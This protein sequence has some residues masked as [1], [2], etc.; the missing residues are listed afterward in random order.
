MKPSLSLLLIGLI[1]LLSGCSLSP[2]STTDVPDSRPADLSVHYHWQ[3]GSLP[4]PFH[5]EYNITLKPQGQG[6]VV[7]TPDYPSDNVPT[8]TETFTVSAAELD[9]FYQVLFNQGLF[10]Q[11]WRAQ[12]VP[13]IGG[14]SQSVTVM[15]H[16][17]K[18]EIPAYVLPE[19][20]AAA[21]AICSAVRALVPEAIW[22]K[23]DTQR[24]Q[25][26]QEQQQ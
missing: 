22:D 12:A 14:S 1:A 6:K 24:Q 2:N 13:P 18:I 23:L 17:L 20:E 10:R 5:Y 26:I 25:Y 7:L 4:P 8:W 21:V 3:E 16:G 9:Q 11:T 19:Q 15:A